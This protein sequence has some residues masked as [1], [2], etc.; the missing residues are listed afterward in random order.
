MAHPSIFPLSSTAAAVLAMCFSAPLLAQT[1]SGQ[2]AT[3]TVS[4][5]TAPV[6]DAEQA[7]VSGLGLRL[8]RAPQS[9]SVLGAD[10]LA[11]TDTRTL[12]QLVKLDA[13]LADSYNTTGYL[14]SLSVRGFV[15]DQN[16]NY[17][18]NGLALPNH[19]PLAIEN[20][21]RAE[22]LKGISGMQQGV[23]APGGLVNWVTKVPQSEA[24][25]NVTLGLDERGGNTLHLD[26]NGHWGEVGVRVNVATEALHPHMDAAN[27]Q[28]EL[29]AVA[30]A[31]KLGRDSTWAADLEYNHKRQPSVPGL[32]LLDTNGDGV[33][34]TLPDLS[35]INP[36]LNL[37]NQSW[38]QP[39][40]STS[41]VAQLAVNTKLSKGWSSRVALGVQRTLTDD[42]LAFPDGCSNAAPAV[43]PGLCANGDVDMYDYR[44]EGEVRNAW[45]WDA[46]LQGPVTA[47]GLAHRLT[48]GL[49]GRSVSAD[50]TATQTY[51]W[52]GTTNI[53]QPIP[54]PTTAT[55]TPV[56]NTNTRE[57]ALD[58]YASVVTDVTPT[59]QSV[60]GLRTSQLQ[61]SSA[62]TNGTEA[63]SLAQ[64][65]TTPW[66]ALSWNVL[67]TTTLYASW[68]QGVEAEV[69][70]NRPA[71]A[72][73]GEV[74]PALVS[75]QRELGVKWQAQPRLQLSAALF[76]IDKPYSAIVGTTSVAGAK[77][78]RHNGLELAANGQLT[79]L[80]SL[81][82]SLALLDA[83]YI[84]SADATLL[85]QRVVNVPQ[86]K[87]SLF[88]DYKL[89]AWP[90]A[91]V[92]GLFSFESGK[93][94][95]SDGQ[96]RLPDAWQ[97]DLGA[98][99]VQNWGKRSVQW[100]LGVDNVTDRSYWREA[101]TTAW[102]GT[103]LFASTP[104]T[105]KASVTVGF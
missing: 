88:S 30:L 42:R 83:R 12:S 86:R 79:T 84:T 17:Q 28:R 81:Q 87:L 78:A 77:V 96:T 36:R 80:W 93:P 16:N 22:V 2:L 51:E 82:A 37:N 10:L 65:V 90:G 69:V 99:L 23:S 59:L 102:G 18:R 95:T 14:E 25:S 3:V 20:K 72:N 31:G 38:S 74:L 61:R 89:A 104:R 56:L 44:S 63:T 9:V 70:P 35:K 50:L 39:Y 24:F 41:T 53:Y 26:T 103:Y 29:L 1:P 32:G 8:A 49:S 67:P 68:G 64:T 27:G 94:A 62:K 43:Y 33:G 52:L 46:R 11:A 34:D 4:D 45:A 5:K 15:L 91:S 58:V 21:E 73:A 100:R 47:L 92:N 85:D 66:A 55:P 13:S 48:L 76:Q 6:L 57:R 75:T 105:F 40:E 71:F 98:S 54:V 60:L 7:D 101:P 19:A 97:L